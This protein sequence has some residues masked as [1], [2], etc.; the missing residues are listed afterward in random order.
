M[1][2]VPTFY[3]FAG[4]LNGMKKGDRNRIGGIGVSD[5]VTATRNFIRTDFKMTR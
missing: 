4:R 3:V 5:T 1:R 2:S